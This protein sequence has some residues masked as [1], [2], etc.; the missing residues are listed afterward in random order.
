MAKIFV[1]GDIVNNHSNPG[2]IGSNLQKIINETDYAVVNLEGV[3]MPSGQSLK[4]PYQKNGT[5]DYLKKVGFNLMLLANNHIT[6]G[7]KEKLKYTLE[8]IDGHHLERIGAGFSWEEAYRPL[9]K[10]IKDIKV[11]FLNVCEAQIG[12]FVSPNQEYGYAWIG[13]KGLVTEVSKLREAVDYVLVFVHMGL[14]HYDIPLP[15]V[16]EFYKELCDAGASCVIGGHPHTAQGYEFCNGK[17]IA[18]SLGNFFFPRRDRWPNESYSYSMIINLQK[19]EKVS[20]VPV[21]HF[22]DGTQ[23]ETSNDNKLDLDNL[24][25]KLG[26]SYI[27]DSNKMIFDVYNGLLKNLL[28]FA[29]CG[30]N[31]KEGLRAIIGKAINYTIRRKKYIN[32]TLNQRQKLLLRLFENETYRFV[33][34]SYLKNKI[35]I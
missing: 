35:T 29:T 20:V 8:L 34:I 27:E 3:E 23:V 28:L 24:N 32:S 4:G 30:Q 16:R 6:D 2:F 15:E 12:H 11:A 10:E 17:L 7:G 1:C 31:E 13:N 21:F 26:S 18:Y 14:E 33:I 5:V 22:N 25:K 19:G 9:I